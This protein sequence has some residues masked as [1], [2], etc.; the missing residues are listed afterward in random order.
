MMEMDLLRELIG[1]RD[2][3]AAFIAAQNDDKCLEY[4]SASRDD[5]WAREVIRKRLNV[6]SG[7]ILQ[8][9]D[10]AK[11]NAALK[12]LMEEGLSIRQIER[13]TGISRGVIQKI[14]R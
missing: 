1:D 11:R 14:K 5:I 8:S 6:Q 9:W 4:E 7:T 12:Q 2:H 3:Y 13:L 10:K